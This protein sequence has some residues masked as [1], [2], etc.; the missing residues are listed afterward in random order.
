LLEILQS[1]SDSRLAKSATHV[2]DV[3]VDRTPIGNRQ[4]AIGNRQSAIG[5]RQS[6]ESAI[7]NPIVNPQSTIP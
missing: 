7:G 1:S 6:R 4:S 3:N 2:L 5:N